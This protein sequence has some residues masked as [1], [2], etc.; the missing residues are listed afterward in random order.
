MKKGS[1]TIPTGC[2]VVDRSG[3]L[4]PQWPR[5][6]D[7]SLSRSAFNELPISAQGK[8][9]TKA[10]LG[11]VAAKTEHKTCPCLAPAVCVGRS[12]WTCYESLHGLFGCSELS[13]GPASSGMPLFPCFITHIASRVLPAVLVALGSLAPVRSRCRS[14]W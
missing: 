9:K 10:D 7:F 13:S 5:H 8:P 3:E 11:E 1:S 2:D 6:R 12:H 14:V 4:N